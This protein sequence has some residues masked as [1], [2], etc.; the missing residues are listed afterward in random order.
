VNSASAASE[1]IHE[2]RNELTVAK[3]NVEAILDGK[4]APTR[5]RLLSIIQALDQLENLIADLHVSAVEGQTLVRPA[6]INV[7]QL[8]DREYNAL[9]AVAKEKQVEVTINRCSVPAAECLHFYGDPARIGQIVKN[10]MLNAIRYTPRGGSVSVDC[11][12]RADQLEVRISD[13]GPGIAQSEASKIFE[14]GYRGSAA[15]G[16]SG[17]GYGL[18]VVKGLVEAQ[19]GTITASEATTGG[20]AFSVRLP[21]VA[22]SE[23]AC[24]NC[25]MSESE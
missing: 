25:R 16:T 21:G 19:G 9:I 12:R 6:L 2:M 3:I 20:A 22:Q 14:P 15:E 10:V 4:L 13:S 23:D 17:S 24:A 5:E 18:A 8:L 11:G 1:I 7:C